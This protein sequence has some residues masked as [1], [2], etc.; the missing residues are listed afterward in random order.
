MRLRAS[1]ERKEEV[2]P[3]SASEARSESFCRRLGG[4]LTS[5]LVALR[6]AAREQVFEVREPPGYT[7]SVPLAPP[8]ILSNRVEPLS[9][10]TLS[11]PLFIQAPRFTPW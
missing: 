7:G 4:I 10:R 6:A 1:R 2:C 8:Q 3:G 5:F 9:G 11:G